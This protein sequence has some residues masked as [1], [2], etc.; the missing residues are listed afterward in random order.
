MSNMRRWRVMIPTL[1]GS[2]RSRWRII[3][4]R[5][6]NLMQVDKTNLEGRERRKNQSNNEII[7][8]NNTIFNGPT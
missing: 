4:Q 6:M 3:R 5:K 7:I 1:G 8:M 2:R